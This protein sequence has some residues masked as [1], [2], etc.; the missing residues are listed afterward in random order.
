M[1]S[2]DYLVR[3][4]LVNL[5]KEGAID[6]ERRKRSIHL[7]ARN[8]RS[9]LGKVRLHKRKVRSSDKEGAT[10]ALADKEGTMRLEEGA[11][12]QQEGVTHCN[13]QE[14]SIPKVR[15]KARPSTRK[16]DQAI[17]ASPTRG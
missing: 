8:V 3:E 7:S 4:S 17:T 6:L 2:Y 16:N 15:S 9:Y 12:R 10:S 1:K 14:Q 5:L 11:R 13:K